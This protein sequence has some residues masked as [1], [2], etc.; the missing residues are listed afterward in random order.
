MWEDF[1]IYGAQ[2]GDA[3]ESPETNEGYVEND[4]R[5]IFSKWGETLSYKNSIF[6]L[7]LDIVLAYQNSMSSPQVQ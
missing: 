4:T 1:N 3:N 7:L 6:L 5:E 2:G